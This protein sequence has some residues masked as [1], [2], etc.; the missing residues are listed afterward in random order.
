MNLTSARAA[1]RARPETWRRSR[2]AVIAEFAPQSLAE[3]AELTSCKKS[4]LSRTL[5]TMARQTAPLYLQCKGDPR[6][7]CREHPAPRAARRHAQGRG[8][9]GPDRSSGGRRPVA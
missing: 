3:L 9:G 1:G 8:A 6:L 4:N 2:G 5:K 7:G